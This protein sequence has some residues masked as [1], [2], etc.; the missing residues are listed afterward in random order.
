LKKIKSEHAS[1][2]AGLR[3]A[4]DTGDLES[5]P[6]TQPMTATGAHICVVAHITPQELVREMSDVF[7]RRWIRE[8]VP[9]LLYTA[10]QARVIT[11]RPGGFVAR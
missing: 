4:W 8:S 5:L 10:T 11:A 1:L 7:L 6:K 2:S 3:K 9:D